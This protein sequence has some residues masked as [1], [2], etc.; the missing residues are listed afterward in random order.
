M[1]TTGDKVTPI[2]ATW[3]RLMGG[4]PTDHAVNH[5]DGSPQLG[6]VYL[7]TGT[8]HPSGGEPG[9][10]LAGCR[11]IGTR[12]QEI[13][14]VARAF[15]KVVPRTERI[16]KSLGIPLSNTEPIRAGKNL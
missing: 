16:K 8:A 13:S 14:F 5:P 3:M 9:I 11:S 1:I 6:H 10:F 2:K 7:V 4:E 12:G 15:R